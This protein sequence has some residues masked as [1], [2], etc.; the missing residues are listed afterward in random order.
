MVIGDLHMGH[1]SGDRETAEYQIRV[2]EEFIFPLIA[3][4]GIKHVIQTGDFFDARKAIR[5]DTM[6]LVRERFVP[7]TKG[8]HWDILVGNHDMHLKESIFPNSCNELLSGYDNITIHNEPGVVEVDGI[9]IDMIPWICRDNRKQVLDFIANSS[10]NIAVGHF[11]L[12]GFQYYRGMASQGEDAHFLANYSQVWSGHFH[13][14]SKANHI[15]YVGTPY[16]LTFGDADDDRGV[17]VY[18]TDDGTFEFHNNNMPRFSRIYFDHSTF[19]EKNLERYKDMYLNIQVKSRGDTKKFDKLIDKL[20]TIAREV[21]VKDVL[22][23]SSGSGTAP[24]LNNMLTTADIIDQYIDTL[25]ETEEDRT[26][27]KRFMMDLYR[28]AETL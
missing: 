1:R 7:M 18:D 27:I 9:K 8:Q 2:F 12:A 13:T 15:L 25:E 23:S 28:E 6:E 20:I 22:D 19:D 24:T 11:E 21:K 26:K 5:H 4:L 10:N 17:W 14:I 3:K 16:Q